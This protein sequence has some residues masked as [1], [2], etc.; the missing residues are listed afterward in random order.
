MDTFLQTI[1]DGIGTGCVYA[2]L[3]VGLTLTFGIGRI[4]NFAHGEVMVLGAMVAITVMGHSSSVG[5]YVL[6]VLVGIG[7]CALFGVAAERT[8][9]RRTTPISGL[10]ISIGLILVIQEFIAEYWGLNVRSINHVVKGD[11]EVLGTVVPRTTVVIVLT[12][13]IVLAASFLFLQ[14]TKIGLLWRAMSQSP[15]SAM[16]L[17]TATNRYRA[18]AFVV[19]AILAGLAGGLLLLNVGFEPTSGQAYIAIAFS[20]VIVGGVGDPRGAV[21]G[22]L[23]I[24]LGEAFTGVYLQAQYI[25]VFGMLL[26]FF[27]LLVRP[28][29][30]W[31][32]EVEL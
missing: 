10:V 12:T 19:G 3:A 4:T 31:G 5:K 17:G 15:Q 13:A 6:A 1:V 24:G 18:M 29:G 32:R 8:L 2:L 26:L 30:I 23:I 7:A 11:F 28:L 21:V 16:L 27:V 25:R 9:F 22:G 14:K 20:A